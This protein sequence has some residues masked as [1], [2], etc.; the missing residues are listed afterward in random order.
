[1]ALETLFPKGAFYDSQ[2]LL[3]VNYFTDDKGES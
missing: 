3:K 2:M 1:M